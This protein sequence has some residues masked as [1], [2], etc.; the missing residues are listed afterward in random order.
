MD[1]DELFKKSG[2]PSKRKA[3]P[4]RDPN[5]VYKS[6]KHSSSST[7]RHVQVSEDDDIEA[8]PAPPADDEGDDG[9]DYGPS[10]PPED[11][12]GDD[13]E[14]RFFGGGITKTEAEVL[15]Y[16]NGSDAPAVP[17][18]F[19]VAWLKKTSLAF[20]KLINK[21]AQLRARYADEPPKF[22]ESEADLDAAIRG[23]SILAEHPELWKEFV[24]LGSA[25][26]LVGLLAHENADVAVSV[27]EIVGEL[28]GED[29]EA[30]PEEWDVLVDGL[31]EADL[32]GLL[33]GT[34]GRL[35]EADEA[36]REGV[37]HVMEVVENLCSRTET[38]SV[39]GK[40]E[41]LVKWL[42]G[43][44]QKSEKTVSQNKQYAAEILAIL[45]QASPENR[46]KLAEMDAVDAFLQLAAAYRKRDPEK[47]SEEEEFMADSFEVLT[48]LS[49]EPEGKAKLIEAEGVELCLIMLKEGKM[50]KKPSLRLLDH[51]VGGNGGAQACQKVVEEGGLKTLFTM[52]MKKPDNETTE[53]LLSIFSWMLRLLPAN[54]AERIRTLAKFMEKDY[55]KTSKLTKLR[56]EYL[57]RVGA[58]EQQMRQESGG[59]KPEGDDGEEKWLSRRM[60][61]GLFQ[62]QTIN[63]ILAWLIAE[64]DGAREKIQ[65]LLADHDEAFQDLRVQIGEQLDE[66]D[67]ETPD[68]K[69]TRDILS[70]LMDFLQ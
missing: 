5:E 36:D 11:E 23:W 24:R 46:R 65:T 70:T 31:L 18:N 29:V 64:D 19:D 20:E 54:S 41:G 28:T 42:L 50:S 7:S 59:K 27:V 38:A 17:T 12:E 68:G 14:G 3:E 16:V 55:E 22:M 25:A 61:A 45:V 4:I 2:L 32:L 58:V 6:A 30:S 40:N 66:T 56:R 1:I 37:Y 51:A 9:A 53:H 10:A 52:F 60:E 8:G 62:L 26:S 63:V 34:F 57:A 48:C 39:V 21:N 33:V 44:V 67:G 49:D 35:D 43:R 15:T 69:E 47:G 13:E